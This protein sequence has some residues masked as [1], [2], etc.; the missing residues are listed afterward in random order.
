MNILIFFIVL[1]AAIT[2]E[3]LTIYLSYLPVSRRHVT[4]KQMLH[5]SFVV[6]AYGMM[7][8]VLL[9]IADLPRI[10]GFL[11]ASALV[12]LMGRKMLQQSNKQALIS[13]GLYI[14]LALA[15]GITFVSL[16]ST[17]DAFRALMMQTY[18]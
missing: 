17:S 3:F 5:A 6:T 1:A 7:A 11:I 4:Q 13:C 2:V 9:G 15:A 12:Y 18:K 8:G 10:L 16:M 14:G